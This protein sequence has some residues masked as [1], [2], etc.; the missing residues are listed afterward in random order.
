MNGKFFEYL[1]RLNTD[2]N[3]EAFGVLVQIYDKEFTG[4][5]FL[6]NKQGNRIELRFDKY[7]SDGKK[8]LF[9][10]ETILQRYVEVNNYTEFKLRN[11]IEN[12]YTIIVSHEKDVSFMDYFGKFNLTQDIVISKGLRF[13][14]Q[15][16]NLVIQKPG[17]DD[18]ESDKIVIPYKTDLTNLKTRLSTLESEG[19][20]I[21]NV[22]DA[23]L[24]VGL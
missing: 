21:E 15:T 4:K 9:E 10:T 11:K 1:R 22:Y 14:H 23:N 5:L 24:Y 6:I 19:L 12:S 7:T 8:I 17:E 2:D 18:D 16:D 3:L 20:T 13:N